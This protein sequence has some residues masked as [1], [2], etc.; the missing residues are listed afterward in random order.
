MSR[1]KTL[2]GCTAILLTN[3][4]N[5]PYNC[6]F[7]IRAHNGDERVAVYRKYYRKCEGKETWI[8]RDSEQNWHYHGNKGWPMDTIILEKV[9]ARDK[10]GRFVKVTG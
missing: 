10:R 3:M 8:A 1:Y 2:S 9:V 6:I 7:V 5:S 4:V